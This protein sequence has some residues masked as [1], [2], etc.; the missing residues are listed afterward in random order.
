MKPDNSWKNVSWKNVCRAVN[1]INHAVTDAY[2]YHCMDGHCSLSLACA[3]HAAACAQQ[4][5][6]NPA[7]ETSANAIRKWRTWHWIDTTIWGGQL[8]IIVGI[9]KGTHE[10]M[11]GWQM[12]TRSL[13]DG[14]SKLRRRSIESNL[15]LKSCPPSTN[16]WLYLLQMVLLLSNASVCF[17]RTGWSSTWVTVAGKNVLNQN[18]V[19]LKLKKK[20]KALTLDMCFWEQNTMC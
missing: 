3:Q 19:P 2:R 14:H 7:T 1:I 12:V 17:I 6:R 20:L 13:E 10:K 15:I 9:G 8:Q 5:V 18:P 4:A 11:G 16:D